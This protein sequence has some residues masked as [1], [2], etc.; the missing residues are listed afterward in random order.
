MSTTTLRAAGGGLFVGSGQSG[1]IQS[2]IIA[3]NTGTQLNGQIHEDA[4]SSVTYPNNLITSTA[5]F[6]CASLASRA[7]GTDSTSKPRFAKFLAVPSDGVTTTLAW[8]VARASSVTIAGVGTWN[9]PNNSPTGTVDVT[10]GPSATYSLAA[11][12][13]SANGG[14]YGSVTVGTVGVVP[15]PTSFSDSVIHVGFSLEIRWQRK[16]ISIR[17][18]FSPKVDAGYPACGCRVY[19]IG[20]ALDVRWLGRYSGSEGA[21]MSR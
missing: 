5:F 1:T 2:S 4:C 6:G 20:T 14:N 8:S 16:V 15:A 21:T 10:P 7:P 3:D 9:S 12:A 17:R 11:T 18:G 13:S 19:Q